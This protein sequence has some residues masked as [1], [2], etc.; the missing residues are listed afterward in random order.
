[1]PREKYS[2]RKPFEKKIP[3][4]RL[5]F[6]ELIELLER[7]KF[8]LVEGDSNGAEFLDLDDIKSAPA[9]F[10]GEP[11]IKI[12]KTVNGDIV[13]KAFVLFKKNN[14]LV[15]SG[16]S[17]YSNNSDEESEQFAN[18]IGTELKP[19]SNLFE[20]VARI[21]TS[22]IANI[23]VIAIL[24][25]AFSFERL[26]DKQI[27][28]IGVYSFSETTIQLSVMSIIIAQFTS[29]LLKRRMPVNY[30]PRVNWWQRHGE[31]AI[32]GLFFSLLTAFLIYVVRKIW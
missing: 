2:T 1:M 23:G 24:V 11:E 29:Q 6:N 12:S 5:S 28:Q 27:I 8:D 26:P 16:H 19:Y 20:H 10:S 4:V 31:K 18:Q 13:V 9:R 3:T 7:N 15:R 22:Y 25:A 14:V 21:S 17:L 30:N 32:T